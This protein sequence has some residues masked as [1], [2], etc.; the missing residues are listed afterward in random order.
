MCGI[1][2]FAAH[3]PL[4]RSE[5]VDTV[6]QFLI[7]WGMHT[8]RG[9]D[10]NGI[11]SIGAG[12]ESHISKAPGIATGRIDQMFKWLL[13]GGRINQQ[14]VVLVGHTRQSTGATAQKNVNNHPFSVGAIVGVH[15]GMFMEEDLIAPLLPDMVGDCD[16]EV[17]FRWMWRLHRSGYQYEYALSRMGTGNRVVFY[18]KKDDALYAYAND[19]YQS[20]L[21]YVV[22]DA[23]VW[24]VSDPDYTSKQLEPLPWKQLPRRDLINLL[25]PADILQ[26]QQTADAKATTTTTTYNRT[27]AV[28]QLGAGHTSYKLETDGTWTPVRYDT[29]KTDD[30]DDLE[31]VEWWKRQ[32]GYPY[33]D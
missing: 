21:E 4:T 27:G 30:L 2:S 17:L 26:A 10:A 32:G 20:G 8:K 29:R 22:T 18:D 12:G 24:T 14:K 28:P 11:F 7:S 6:E 31:Y 19:Y 23:G 25:E 13:K 33:N 15:N 1:V 9:L 3:R 5:V 16:S